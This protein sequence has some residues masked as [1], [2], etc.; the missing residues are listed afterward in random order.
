MIRNTRLQ[1]RGV[2]I[3]GASQGLG[4]AIAAACLR[5]G[6]HL[7]LTARDQTVLETA[8]AELRAEAQPGQRVLT[9]AADVASPEEARA[10]VSKA[11]AELPNFSA[12]VNNAG[13]W[14]PMGRL[15]DVPWEEWFAAVNTNLMGTALM[16]RFVIP[17]FRSRHYGKIVNLS[18][19][20]ATAPMP[21][22]SAYAASKAGVVRFTETLAQE[23][24]DAGIRV[25]AIA[26]G[27]L[28]TRMLDQLLTA[29]REKVGDHYYQRGLKQQEEGGASLERAAALAVFLLSSE[30]DAVTG[31]LISA[32]WDAWESLPERAEELARTDVYTLRRIIPKERGLAWEE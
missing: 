30:S 4:K 16:C 32:V 23:T 28:N 24:Q 7:L 14:G 5:E 26:P 27:A 1:D 9:I 15:E 31:R 13:V 18:G 12:L 8:A 2:L 29:G 22:I 19:G 6:A 10:S 17:H 11:I 20:G 25:N 21:R 3:T